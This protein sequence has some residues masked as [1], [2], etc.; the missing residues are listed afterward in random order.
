MECILINPDKIEEWM[1]EVEQ[2][3]SSAPLIIR[4]IAGRLEELTRRN[5]ELRAENI[6]LV[7]DKKVEEYES[8]IAGLEYQ[9]AL[10]K[11]QVS[12]DTPGIPQAA[13]P[14]APETLSLVVFTPGGL[15]LRVELPPDQIASASV[16]AN[17]HGVIAP[18][19]VPPGIL[20]TSTQEELLFV[21][22]TG[23]TAALP[24]TGIPVLDPHSLDWEQAFLQE[25]RASEELAVV[26][27][28]SRMSLYEFCIQTS[29]KG[30]VKKIREPSL[31]TYI[32]NAYLGTGVIQRSDKMCSLVLSSKQDRFGMVSQQGYFFSME[33]ERLPVAIE[34]VMKLDTGDHIVSTFILGKKPS[35]MIAT[36]TGKAVLRDSAWLEQATSFKTKGQAV[37]SRERRDSGVRIVGAAAV[38]EN[39][40]GL[41]LKSNGD[42]I[43]YNMS[44][45]F[46]TGSLLPGQSPAQV[47]G[48]T[49]FRLPPP[50]GAQSAGTAKTLAA[51]RGEH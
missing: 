16:V 40:W 31:E 9:L 42:F 51:P 15:V 43:A 8:R 23:R 19:G 41:V 24:V 45:L 7:S 35:L 14:A 6:A 49:T 28:I 34:E 37:L 11:R 36:Q 33:V 18:D 48:F 27:P 38:D 20:V 4:Y 2:R 30:F 12:G 32:A 10:L 3:P 26:L 5:E 39:D 44:D 29:R 25:P 13:E 47:L 46:A 17:F 22:D 50:A 1:R 21:F